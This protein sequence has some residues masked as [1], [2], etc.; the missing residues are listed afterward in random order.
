[1]P[2]SGRIP[3]VRHTPKKDALRV[4]PSDGEDRGSVIPTVLWRLHRELF[5][6]ALGQ[7]LASNG[8]WE[9]VMRRFVSA[10]VAVLVGIGAVQAAGVAPAFAAQKCSS[11][12]C[13]N[14]TLSFQTISGK[15]YV[16]G[17][18]SATGYSSTANI[19]VDYILYQNGYATIVDSG[20]NHCGT[21]RPCSSIT[22][23]VAV[24]TGREY[25]LC[26]HSWVSGS[27]I[28][29]QACTQITG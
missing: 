6:S 19:W 14:S 10:V 21:H 24:V 2:I 12:G 28:Q 18:A 17:T 5:S 23:N 22:Y 7:R 11:S 8:A 29:P 26:V 15:K 27:S 4:R 3:R 16:Y 20:S 13:S 9:G 25:S 1:M